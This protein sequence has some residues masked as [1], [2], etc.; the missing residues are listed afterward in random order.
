MS[1]SVWSA[2]VEIVKVFSKSANCR[3]VIVIVLFMPSCINWWKVSSSTRWFWFD[4][5]TSWIDCMVSNRR[6]CIELLYFNWSF[7][8]RL[9]HIS[10]IYMRCPSPKSIQVRLPRLWR[11]KRNYLLT[12]RLLYFF[13]LW[14]GELNPSWPNV[15]HFN[16]L[17]ASMW[18]SICCLRTWESFIL[19]ITNRREKTR[20]IQIWMYFF[21]EEKLSVCTSKSLS[22]C[23]GFICVDHFGYFHLLGE[24]TSSLSFLHKSIIRYWLLI[25][26]NVEP[27]TFRV[28]RHVL[29]MI[30]D[31]LSSPE[32]FLFL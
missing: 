12:N 18:M 2:Q 19:V 25:L 20:R 9:W 6:H 30:E 27:E 32:L 4:L 23:F 1:S 10:D 16:S 31:H 15:I 8:W 29:F 3:V 24:W 11:R 28:V 17:F 26:E 7:R 13:I 5:R 14:W 21:S 22:R